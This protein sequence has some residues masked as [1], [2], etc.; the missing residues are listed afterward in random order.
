MTTPQLDTRTPDRR[1][2]DEAIAAEPLLPPPELPADV[3]PRPL[4]AFLP[5]A[6]KPVAV[7]G[8]VENGVVR[9]LDPAVRLPERSRVIIVAN[10]AV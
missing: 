10:E 6:R 7:T 5:R 2:L 1:A 8:V 3:A 9:P 4:E